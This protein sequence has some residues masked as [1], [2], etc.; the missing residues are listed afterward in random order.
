M[1]IAVLAI[2]D[3]PMPFWPSLL[4]AASA[5]CFLPPAFCL[6]LSAL[7]CLLPLP[8]PAALTTATICGDHAGHEDALKDISDH[9]RAG[10]AHGPRLPRLAGIAT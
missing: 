6:L 2:A 8:L 7:L 10:P 4:F 1:P 5:F 9:Y 3:C